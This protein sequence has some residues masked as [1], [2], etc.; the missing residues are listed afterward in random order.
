M[1]AYVPPPWITSA[2]IYWATCWSVWATIDCFLAPKRSVVVRTVYA[3]NTLWCLQWSVF[4]TLWLT[5]VWTRAEYLDFVAPYAPA[6]FFAGPWSIW[7][8][9]HFTARRSVR[10]RRQSVSDLQPVD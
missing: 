8:I 5:G 1:I 10:R 7:S 4:L 2:C 6:V 3:I 9:F